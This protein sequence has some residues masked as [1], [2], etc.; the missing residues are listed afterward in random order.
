MA[1]II[2]PAFIQLRHKPDDSAKSAFIAQVENTLNGA[3]R[4]LQRFSD[5]AGEATDRAFAAGRTRP[6]SE[7]YLAS[8]DSTLGSAERR[9]GEFSAEARRMLDQVTSQALTPMGNLDLGVPE[10]QRQAAA[11]QQKA[12]A[13]REL[14]T[15]TELA[16]KEAGDHSQ[17]ARLQVAAMQAAA[18]EAEQAAGSAREY[19]AAQAQVQQQLNRTVSQVQTF[20]S[21]TIKGAAA[22]DNMRMGMQQLGYQLNDISTMFAM[23]ARGSQIFASQA[24][25]VVQAVQLMA[26]GTSRLASFLGGPWGIA[27]TTATIALTPFIG[28]L[29]DTQDALDDL[30]DAAEKAMQKVRQ[31]LADSSA[32]T[33]AA[34]ESVTKRVNAMGALAKAQREIAEAESQIEGLV[35]IPGGAQ[36]V[37]GYQARLADASRRKAEAERAIQEAE[38]ALAEL[39]GLETV[40]AIQERN[41][42]RLSDRSSTRTRRGSDRELRA[43]Q[44]L[45][46]FGEDAAKKIANIAGSFA[47]IPAEVAR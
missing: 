40:R 39:R 36:M 45:A 21:A 7:A 6:L 41:Q 30:G 4:R 18:R 26:G 43:A 38:A 29:F 20:G 8:I 34:T 12:V 16:A 3:E 35:R 5:V 27:L 19:A 24:G 32:F 37:Q 31:T 28:R 11:L 47:D 23:G 15:A 22:N 1:E 25:Q 44:S 10:L 42:E 13:A 9:F 2:F 14:A 46:E 17:T 33:D